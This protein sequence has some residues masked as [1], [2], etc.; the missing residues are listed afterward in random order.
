VETWVL[1]GDIGGT[2]TAL[3]IYR[4]S[5]HGR[6]TL[7]RETAYPSGEFDGLEAILADFLGSEGE[8][9]AAACFGAAGPRLDGRVRATN[10][11]WTLDEAALSEAV[12]CERVRL[13]NDLEAT[14]H[15]SLFLEGDALRTL[16]PGLARP[17][18]RAVIAAG[19]GLGQAL[20]FHDGERYQAVATEG[21]HA[22][23]APRDERQIELLR[24]LSARFGRVSVERV[25]SGPGLVAIFDFLRDAGA[26]VAPE[27][28][29]RLA[30][31]D[32]AAVIGEAGQ[33]GACATCREALEIFV[34][35]YGAQ[36]ANL[37]LT[38]MALGGVYLGGGIAPKLLPTLEGGLFLEAFRSAG[39]FSEL[40][41]EV[42]V[43]VILE[44]AT[45]LRGAA[46][47]AIELARR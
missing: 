40:L 9:I 27:V 30:A 29:A 37:V 45:A 8:P 36:A 24:F 44:P 46:E 41:A 31:D 4:A 25:V 47:L 38:A 42:P 16:C 14:A 32:P 35:A 11:P 20:L 10:L 19:T 2:K 15:G 18:H 26:P 3:A 12:G 43:H 6:P 21:G 1:A 5:A 39:R 34:A 17:T 7:H 13:V 28:V 22:A 33:S 23:F